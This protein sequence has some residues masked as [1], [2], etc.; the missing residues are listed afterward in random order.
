MLKLKLKCVE[1]MKLSMTCTTPISNSM[2]TC[3]NCWACIGDMLDVYVC[4][5]LCMFV[6]F[7]PLSHKGRVVNGHT[8]K[9]SNPWCTENWYFLWIFNPQVSRTPQQTPNLKSGN[10]FKNDFLYS[11]LTHLCKS[12][13]SSANTFVENTSKIY[14]KA[15]FSPSKIQKN[16]RLCPLFFL[17]TV[18]LFIYFCEGT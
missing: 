12:L 11:T 7:P 14:F 8:M 4:V 13:R 16:R 18:N 10:L 5:C 6:F 9:A 2:N 17:I 15:H 3:Y 1:T